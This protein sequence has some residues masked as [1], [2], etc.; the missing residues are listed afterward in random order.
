MVAKKNKVKLSVSISEHNV[1]KIEHIKKIYPEE[2]TSSVIDHSLDMSLEE[3]KEL[4]KNPINLEK[5]KLKMALEDLERQ[6]K[7][8]K[9]INQ[10]KAKEKHK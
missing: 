1:N 5:A 8:E 3:V 7:T 4:L 6:E 10:L 9:L 2:T